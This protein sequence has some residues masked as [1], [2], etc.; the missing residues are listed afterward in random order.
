MTKLA[1]PKQTFEA[2]DKQII[3]HL[4]QQVADLP[5][6]VESELQIARQRALLLAQQRSKARLGANKSVINTWQTTHFNDLFK[7]NLLV[8]LALAV[9]LAI[10]VNYL[11][12]SPTTLPYDEASVAIQPLPREILEVEVLDEDL[13]L[14]QELE[15]A[16]WLSQQ[17]VLQ[18]TL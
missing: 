8:P 18:E 11:Q 7:S 4:D 10:T 9:C 17:T 3:Q 15:F 16:T 6:S 13:A 14:L 2:I 12:L 1:K 5:E